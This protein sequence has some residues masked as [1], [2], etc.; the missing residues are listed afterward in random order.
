M[1]ESSVTKHAREHAL[2][3]IEI[4]ARRRGRDEQQRDVY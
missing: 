4:C 3:C 1:T 2:R